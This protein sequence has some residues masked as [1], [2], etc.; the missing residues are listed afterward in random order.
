MKLMLLLS[1]ASAGAIQAPVKDLP[2]AMGDNCPQPPATVSFL[3]GR[4]YQ[5][6]PEEGE[7]AYK[8]VT[9]PDDHAHWS[10]NFGNVARPPIGSG[11]YR[12]VDSWPFRSI[13]IMNFPART[14]DAYYIFNRNGVVIDSSQKDAI[15]E[16]MVE[17]TV[18]GLRLWP[19]ANIYYRMDTRWIG[20][21]GMIYDPMRRAFEPSHFAVIVDQAMLC[22]IL[23]EAEF[24][25]WPRD[26]R[27]GDN[28]GT[29]VNG[30]CGGAESR[31]FSFPGIEHDPQ[32]YYTYPGF[33]ISKRELF[34]T[35]QRH[36]EPERPVRDRKGRCVALCG[37]DESNR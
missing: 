1:L 36:D 32:T 37:S 18:S 23:E 20:E 11:G 13:A 12:W 17:I 26:R 24:V 7:D 3:G 33:P 15:D 21:G 28:T 19:T 35:F 30:H 31:S 22:P 25:N 27:S 9:P 10:L 16:R 34:W 4:L 29:Y 5:C 8:D 2:T 6:E 14:R